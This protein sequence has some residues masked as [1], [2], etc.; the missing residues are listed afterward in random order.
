MERIA[1]FCASYEDLPLEV[2]QETEALGQWMGN[3]GYTLVYGGIKK[4]L[5]E[6]LAR[7]VKKSGGR[8]MGII[9]F[10]MLQQSL[11]SENVDIE[12]PVSNLN[13]RKST[14]LRESDAF[15]ALPGG[16]GT[17]DELFCMVASSIVG[18]HHKPVILYNIGGHWDALLACLHDLEERGYN[19]RPLG[20]YLHVVNNLD[21]LS[22]LIN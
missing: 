21:E 11:S 17:L 12:I 16:I 4:G 19:K 9:P 6:I 15:I 8:V 2:R 7:T 20:E 22:D 10:S 18:E 14:M 1:I 5:M 3:R 13:D